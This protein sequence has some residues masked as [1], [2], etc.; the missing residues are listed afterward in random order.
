MHRDTLIVEDGSVRIEAFAQGSGPLVLLLPSLGRGAEDFDN[1]SR[2]IADHGYRVICPQ[3]RGI[4]GSTGPMQ[5]TTLHDLARDI[6][7]VIEQQGGSP[8][9]VAGHAFGNWVARMLAADRPDQVR[10]VVLL[11]AAHRT[12]EPAMRLSIDKCS[13]P[14]VAANERLDHLRR[15]YFAAGNDATSW[16]EGWHKAVAETQRAA[17]KAVSQDAWWAAG[18]RV[19][20]LDVQGRDDAIAPNTGSALLREELGDRVTTVV[21]SNAGHALLPEQPVAVADAMLAFIGAL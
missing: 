17:G 3:P 2:L 7:R 10:G 1:V 14:S 19:P 4:G 11:A 21:I 18:G 5:G 9:I 12:I 6:A 13:D 20:I 8:A 15:A 16:L